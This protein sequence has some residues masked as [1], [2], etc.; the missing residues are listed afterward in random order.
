[1]NFWLKGG[2][3]RKKLIEQN[4]PKIKRMIIKL[5]QIIYHKFKLKTSKNFTKKLKSK[6]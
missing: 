6:E 2:I 4:D 1:M 5:E 3:E